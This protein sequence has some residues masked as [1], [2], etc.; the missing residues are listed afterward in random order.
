MKIVFFGSSLFAVPSLKALLD[1][2]HKVLAVSTQP[3]RAKGRNLKLSETPV[4][5]LALS[6][7]IKNIY[8]PEKISDKASIKYLKS[9]SADL[10]VVVAYGEIL[11]KEILEVPKIYSI[12]LHAS[13]LPKYRG[14][15]PINR[16]IING[17]TKTG[18]SIIKMNEKMD[19]GDILLKRSVEIEPDDTSLTLDRKLSELGGILILDAIRFIELDKV[20][21]KKQDAKKVS[22][23]PKLK[24]EDGLIDWKNPAAKIHNMVR[25]LVPW[26]CAYTFLD[27]KLLK[28]WKTEVLPSREK[29]Q[30]GQ[31]IDAGKNT[32]LVSAGKDLL[33]IKELQ[34]EGKNRM[35]AASF[36]RGHKIERGIFLGTEDKNLA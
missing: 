12:N 28:V 9:L 20:T 17:E 32:I 27:T 25:G 21:F 15:A 4:K 11:P 14:A 36:M 24:K 35:D 34:L 30:P 16:A 1:S 18:F 2:S 19:A 22:F 6:R 13:L 29:R 3:D 31:V 23:A 7:G 33:I 10:F 8:Q 26:P 5:T